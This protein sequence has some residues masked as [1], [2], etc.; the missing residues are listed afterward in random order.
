[1]EYPNAVGAR[2]TGEIFSVDEI[3][4]EL[5]IE[6]FPCWI[7]VRNTKKARGFVR[8]ADV[9]EYPRVKADVIAVAVSR[10]PSSRA[11]R[12]GIRRWRCRRPGGGHH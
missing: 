11:L 7:H 6:G 10:R 8:W 9:A 2:A 5:F 1:M 4:L 12:R 3:V